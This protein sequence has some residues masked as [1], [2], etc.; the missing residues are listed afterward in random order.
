MTD[1]VLRPV[2]DGFARADTFDVVDAD[3]GELLNPQDPDVQAAALDACRR[4]ESR[5]KT[6]K[7]FL[8]QELVQRTI[9]HAE[10]THTL[11]SGQRI[12]REGGPETVYTNPHE[13]ERELL[14][15][16]CPAERVATIVVTTIDKKVSGVEAAKAA[17][18]N[19]EYAR[20]IARHSTKVDKPYSIK[21][22]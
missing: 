22:G 20:I 21:L 3:T 5:L 4:E 17:R 19:E 15:A 1:I 10:R 13:L 11:P 18:S 12:V 14:A 8:N 16:G 2:T 7:R 6:F 9:D